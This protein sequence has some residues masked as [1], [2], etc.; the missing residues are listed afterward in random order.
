[1]LEHQ[2]Q[3]KQSERDYHEANRIRFIEQGGAIHVVPPSVFA[4]SDAGLSDGRRPEGFA[5]T[6][7]KGK[8][9]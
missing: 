3:L 1:M 7:T 9:K 6:T 5:K 4:E 8:R 2:V